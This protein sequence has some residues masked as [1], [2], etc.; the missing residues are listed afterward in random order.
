[1]ICGMLSAFTL[2][3]TMQV[4]AK[5]V[6]TVQLTKENELVCVKDSSFFKDVFS[7]MAPGDS[8]TAVIR[9]ENQNENDASFFLSHKTT[10]TLEEINKSAGGAYEFCVEIGNETNKW[11]LLDTQAGGYTNHVPGTEGLFEIRELNEYR[12]IA[13]LACGG[14]T[15]VYVTLTLDGEGMDSA[16]GIDYSN[17]SGAM[18]FQFCA[19]YEKDGIPV[20]IP[21]EEV[22]PTPQQTVTLLESVKT[23]D[24]VWIKALAGILCAA[25]VGLTAAAVKKERGRENEKN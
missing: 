16:G 24:I 4:S 12:C 14:V 23:G 9:I 21:Q 15:N 7:G 5:E 8:R 3:F 13:Q 1:M 6:Q 11:T 10:D 18:Q 22:K 17:A 2:V 20:L 19:Y 25:G